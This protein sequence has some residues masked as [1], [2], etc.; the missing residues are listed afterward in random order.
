MSGMMPTI[1]FGHG[2]PMNALARNQY[3]G[4]WAT[5]ESKLPQ[6]E[7]IGRVAAEL[8][9]QGWTGRRVVELEGRHRVTPKELAATFSKV[10]G[11]SVQVKATPRSTWKSFSAL[12][13]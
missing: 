6:T 2:N 4:V 13:E 12:R 7:D 10:L 5:I 8:L 9:Q 11:R 3:T 1:F